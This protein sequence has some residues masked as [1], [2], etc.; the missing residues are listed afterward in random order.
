MTVGWLTRVGP[1]CL[2]AAVLVFQVARGE[3]AEVPDTSRLFPLQAEVTVDDAP[4]SRLI[5][6]PEVLS[7]CRPDLS[8]LRLFDDA[9]KE[10]PFLVDTGMP[11][12]DIKELRE[13]FEPRVLDASRAETRRETGPP[14]RRETLELSLPSSPPR[15][16]SWVLV[17]EPA[18]RQFV[19]RVDV[20][21]LGDRGEVLPL[22][23]GGSLFRLGGP[24]DAEKTR[25]PLPP[26]TATRLRLVLETEHP[27]W[28]EPALRLESARV[29]EHGARMAIPLDIVSI[30]VE[31][32]HTIVDLAR[33]SG[34]V[35]DLLRV[36]TAT[37]TFDRHLEVWDDARAA[38]DAAIGSGRIFRV[39]ALVPAGDNEIFLRIAHGERLR[40]EIDDGDSP[41]LESPIFSAVIRQPS[42]VFPGRGAMLRFGGGRAHPP[43]YDLAGLLPSASEAVTGRRAEA[44]ALLY[45]PATVHAARLGPIG[46][47]PRYDRSP[48]LAFAMHSGGSLDPGI[49]SHSRQL[50]IPDSPEGLSRLRIE[51]ADLAVMEKDLADLRVTDDASRQWP[52][53]LV[54]DA[55]TTMVPLAAGEP[56]RR[57]SS[58]RYS[59]QLPASPLLFDRMVLDTDAAFFD[60]TV[61]IKAR[62][63]DGNEVTAW[64]GRVARPVGDPRAVTIET[65]PKRVVSLML[66][67]ENGDDAPLRLSAVQVRAPLPELFVTAPSGAYTLLIGAPGQK[68]PRYELERLRDVVLA[69]EAAPI[70]A[71]PLE[72]NQRYSLNARLKGTGVTQT[73]LLWG[74]LIAAVVVLA[75]FTLRLARGETPTV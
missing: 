24:R 16:G 26:F 37:T 22:L 64:R 56:E 2:G 35:P 39:P 13:Q 69:V 11:P 27:F 33:P 58:S 63:E 23:K 1:A 73:L 34:I 17:V 9:G 3:A 65:G 19:A 10:L 32:R 28:L 18:A 12:P 53:L 43:R 61:L 44:A 40:V 62:L 15:S 41:P 74:T 70:A 52:Y 75:F 50:T 21:G 66:E 59:L 38:A 60:R 46:P 30:R 20:E 6:P 14:L 68:P 7:A 51:P 5:L 72:P 29:I 47:N 31:N 25:L 36:E 42:L 54:R 57:G 49:F 45:D 48:A 4:L 55:A 67:I 8:D 71:G